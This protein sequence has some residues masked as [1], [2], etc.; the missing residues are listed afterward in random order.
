MKKILD[1]QEN[2]QPNYSDKAY[3]YFFYSLSLF[4]VGAAT[5]V[6]MGLNYLGG[7]MPGLVI[8]F[9]IIIMAWTSA[10][11]LFNGI[12]S[13]RFKESDKFKMY[14][15]TLGNGLFFLFFLA[16]ILANVS[17]IFYGMSN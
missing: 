11:G 4:G 17:D 15:G 10:V 3:Q 8:G 1:L 2:P 14:I 16:I 9:S 5:S 12:Q 7:M 13:F 6:L